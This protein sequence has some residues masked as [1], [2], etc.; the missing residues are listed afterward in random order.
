MDLSQCSFAMKNLHMMRYITQLWMIVVLAVSLHSCIQQPVKEDTV[1][2]KPSPQQYAWQEQERIMFIHFG[3]ATWQ[4]REYDN[5]STDLSRINPTGINTDDWCKTAQAFG[6]KQIIF[7]AKHVG[8]FCWWPTSTTDYNVSNTPWKQGK[9]DLVAEVAASCKKY[10]LKLGLYLYPGDDKWG[11]GLGSGGRTEDTTKQAAYNKVYRQQ[12]TELLTNYGAITE[13]W[14]DGTCVINV[15]DILEKYAKNAVIFQSPQASIRWVGNEEGYAPYPAWNSLSSTDLSTGVATAVQG[16]PDGDA[17]APLECDVPLYNHNWF[18][19]PAN[20]QKRRSVSE[21]MKIYYRSVGRGAMMLLNA[22][23]D[24][25]GVIPAADVARFGEF[26][27]E[28]ERRF[29]HPLKSISNKRG[30]ETVIE[31]DSPTKINHVVI[32]EDYREGERIRAYQVEGWTGN[33]WKILSTGS[34]IGRKK[35]DFFKDTTVSKVKLVVTK[36]VG[37]PILRSID[38]YYITDT[39]ELFEED[40]KPLSAW[41]YLNSWMPDMFVNNTFDININLTPYIPI[42][43]QYEVK[44]DPEKGASVKVSHAELWYDG[45]KVLDEFITISDS[46]VSINRTAQ[47]TNETSILLKLKLTSSGEKKSGSIRFRKKE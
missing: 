27:K 31:L 40:L 13:V 22:T 44:I 46:A 3:M 39:P 8:G 43:G 2:A 47:V 45:Q 42:P 16:N 24:T 9:G 35:I 7:V 12:L 14:F 20:E 28:M 38:L 36:S 21:L 11:A 19:S 37:E 10:G 15:K 25:M 41:K 30:K 32:M 29:S 33:E 5:F 23:P 34:S 17:W 4:G 6:A 26:G 1:L 18:W